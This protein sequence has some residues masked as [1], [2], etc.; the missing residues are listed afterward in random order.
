MNII[1]LDKF[2]IYQE[3]RINMVTLASSIEINT[4]IDNVINE[5]LIRLKA[6]VLAEEKESGN[7]TITYKIPAVPE[8]IAQ[9]FPTLRELPL[10]ILTRTETVPQKKRILYPEANIVVPQLGSAR[11]RVYVEEEY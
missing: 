6:F 10:E 8:S 7:V 9:M 11:V 2:P 3:M 4:E 1:E 5:M